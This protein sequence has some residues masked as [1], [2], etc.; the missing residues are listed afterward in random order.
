MPPPDASR[1]GSERRHQRSKKLIAHRNP[2]RSGNVLLVIGP[3]SALP[4][5]EKTATASE[6]TDINPLRSSVNAPDQTRVRRVIP[7]MNWRRGT[8]RDKVAA[9]LIRLIASILEINVHFDYVVVFV[10]R[11]F[12]EEELFSNRDLLGGRTLK[13][14]NRIRLRRRGKLGERWRGGLLQNRADRCALI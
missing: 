13:L 7:R 2:F 3:G 11:R 12:F 8:K 6:P 14:N 5:T 1:L 4:Q 9:A 10:L